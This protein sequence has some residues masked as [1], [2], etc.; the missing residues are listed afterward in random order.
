[1]T[2]NTARK[3]GL[4]P[5]Y[6]ENHPLGQRIFYDIR[7]GQYYDAATDLY[8]VNYDPHTQQSE[9]WGLR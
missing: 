7:E 2:H 6:P 4:D 5:I 9:G 8:L 1:M 3:Q